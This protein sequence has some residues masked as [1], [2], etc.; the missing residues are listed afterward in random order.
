MDVTREVGLGLQK[1]IRSAECYSFLC[2]RYA[3]MESGMG[4]KHRVFFV[5]LPFRLLLTL[6]VARLPDV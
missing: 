4:G 6:S 3:V 1:G 5:D 2:F